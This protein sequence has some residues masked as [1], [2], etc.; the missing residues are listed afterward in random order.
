MDIKI[1]DFQNSGSLSVLQF[2][3]EGKDSFDYI[4]FS[5]ALLSKEIEVSEVSESG[6][7]N[8][9]FII[10]HSKKFVF[11]M[12]GDILAGAKQ[13]RVLNT[14]VLLYPESKTNV[15]VSCVESGRWRYTSPKFTDSDYVA[16]AFIRQSKAA[17]VSQNVSRSGLFASDQSKVWDDVDKAMAFSKV[18][19]ESRNLSDIVYERRRDF[20]SRTADFICNDNSNGFVLFNKNR[21]LSL[22]VFNRSDVFKEYF[23]KILKGAI[24]ELNPEEK[25]KESFNR[26]QA[27]DTLNVLLENIKQMKQDLH[28]SVGAGNEKRF[29]DNR[30][31]GFVFLIDSPGK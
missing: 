31:T 14:S 12:D 13:N 29:G 8:N 1:L 6:S 3:M 22:D 17:S 23:P 9:L 18:N 15:P 7:V 16:P 11:F 2:E 24:M 21:I 28:K 5:K 19:S 27:S 25:A 10:N 30:F 26:E 20:E 4:T